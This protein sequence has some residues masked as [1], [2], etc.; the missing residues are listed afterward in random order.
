MVFKRLMKANCLTNSAV[1]FDYRLNPVY[2]SVN[3]TI[4]DGK[5]HENQKIRAQK[6]KNL[7][8]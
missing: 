2:E 5:I 7:L 6:V 1:I 3:K 8:S 4:H